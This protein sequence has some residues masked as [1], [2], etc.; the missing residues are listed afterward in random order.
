MWRRG[1]AASAGTCSRCR[2]PTTWRRSTTP[3]SGFLSHKDGPTLIVVKSIIGYGAPTKAGTAKAHGEALGDEEIAKT[4]AVYG[5]PTDAK[6][7]VP[8]EVPEAFRRRRSASAAQRSARRGRSCWP[9]TRRSIPSSR[10]ELKHDVGARAARRLGR[11]ICPCSRPS[12]K[13]DG[14]AHLRR[15]SRSTRSPRRF[16]GCLGGSADLAPS[17]KTLLTFDEAG[18][19]FAADNPGGRNLHFGIREHGMAAAVNGMVLCGL[20]AYGA[21]FF[22]FCDY[23]RPSLR[24][25]AIMKIPSDR[26][27]HARFDR[28][29]RRRPDASAGRAPRRLPG[30]SEPGR[31]AAGRRERS[32]RSPGK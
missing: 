29:R 8:P 20:R 16:P 25:A 3:T 19:D 14:H 26:R 28:R 17:T 30:D 1:S 32:G 9:T 27:V 11:A 5:W 21:T 2:T 7:L 4:K 18:G 10:R 23:C 15:Q 24:L 6:F 12:D 31:A 13:G 22:V